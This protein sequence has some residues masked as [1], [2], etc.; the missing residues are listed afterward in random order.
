M[1]EIG[2]ACQENQI[3][4]LRIGTLGAG[5]GWEREGEEKRGKKGRRLN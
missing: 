4:D 5:V 3:G 1:P 2:A